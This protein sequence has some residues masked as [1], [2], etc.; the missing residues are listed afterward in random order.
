VRADNS[1]EPRRRDLHCLRNRS[2]IRVPRQHYLSAAPRRSDRRRREPRFA[3]LASRKHKFLAAHGHPVQLSRVIQAEQAVVQ[4]PAR[5]EFA[6]H[7]RKMPAR[8]LHPA[9][10]IQFCKQSNQHAPSLPC[11]VT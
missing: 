1:S 7:G 11:V 2:Q 10:P 6:K 3:S 5:G 9:R 4:V 8:P